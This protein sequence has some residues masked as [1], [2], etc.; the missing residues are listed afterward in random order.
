MKG[1]S[2]GTSSLNT[3][4][5]YANDA[6]FLVRGRLRITKR[7]GGGLQGWDWELERSIQWADPGHELD[8]AEIT[9]SHNLGTNQIKRDRCGG[10]TPTIRSDI[11]LCSEGEADREFTTTVLEVQQRH[12]S[13][14]VTVTRTT[15]GAVGRSRIPKYTREM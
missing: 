14:G 9:P 12:A 3:R 6:L 2:R 13:C 7:G 15:E 4:F 1:G 11:H 10:A 5:T 8:Q